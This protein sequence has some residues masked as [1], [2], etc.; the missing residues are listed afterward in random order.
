MYRS[1]RAR[2]LISLLAT[3]FVVFSS[4]MF[5]QNLSVGNPNNQPNA[6]DDNNPATHTPNLPQ[7]P[8]P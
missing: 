4:Q 7:K 6:P 1:K 2:I 8:N 3:I 5:F